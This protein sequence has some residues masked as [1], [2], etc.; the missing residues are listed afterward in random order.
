MG[1]AAPRPKKKLKALHWE[2]VDSPEVT[3][4]GIN[5]PTTEEKEEKYQELS[6]KG[7]LDEIEK[8]FMAKEIKQIGKAG[9]K[10]KNEKKQVIGR[11][12]MHTMQ[13]SLAK[14]SQMEANEI[15]RMIIHCD[16]EV[17][18][19]STVMD[20]LQQEHLCTIPDNTAKLMAPYSKDWTGA[21]A[22][23]TEREQDPSELTKEDQIYLYTAYE[24]HHYWKAR[25]RALALTRNFEADYDEISGKLKQVVNVS[26]SLR[27][28]VRLLPVFGLILDIGNY[29]NDTNKQAMGF[30]LSSLARLGMVKDSNNESTLMDYVER[31]IRNQYPEWE[32]FVDDIAGVA[33]VQKINI[34]QL[35][36]DAKKYIDNI[37]NVQS[38]LDNGNLSDPKKFHPEDR[39]SQIVQRSMKEARR[40]AEQMQLYL[41]EMNRIYDDIL[42]FFGDDNRDENARREFFTKLANFLNEYKKSHEKNIGLEEQ[43]KRNEANM[44]RKQLNAQAAN[45][46]VG[47]EAA[48]PSPGANT[49]AMDTLLE[50]LRAAAPQT[51]DTRDRR[52]R[53]RLKDRHQVRVAS[54]QQ[55]PETGENVDGDTGL[56]SPTTTVDSQEGAQGG[57]PAGAVSEGEDIADRAA[58]MLQGLRGDEP[59]EGSVGPSDSLRVR[60]RRE[61]ADEE[62]A[63]R[64]ARRRAGNTSTDAG[65][66]SQAPTIAEEAEPETVETVVSVDDGDGKRDSG[67]R[68][69]MSQL[70]T[71]T[72]VVV[73]PSPTSSEKDGGMT[74][75][76]T[77]SGDE[78]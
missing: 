8:L 30:K 44:R 4:W 26:E 66:P 29:M 35:Q 3:M 20:F 33:G 6:K 19:N 62:R 60:R 17:I 73:P 58:S 49:G 37:N 42:T 41:A 7:I 64:R 12:L 24:L 55:I 1:L 77:K 63:R 78:D 75:P 14:F 31:V 54:G 53:A 23:S 18:D 40:K 51:R 69:H 74:L 2:K 34:E 50:K 46:A 39:V 70:P 13:I 22:K 25:M 38:S 59:S 27:D 57:E 65:V 56:L 45:A 48:P 47:V 11:D 16:K 9:A 72:T 5:T 68:A 10:G 76:P 67:E 15:V 28:S 32:G 61:S 43:W 36:G 52:R 71:P 21:D